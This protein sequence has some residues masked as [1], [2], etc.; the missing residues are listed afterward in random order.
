MTDDS[1]A[2]SY[3]FAALRDLGFAQQQLGRAVVAY[4]AL[5]QDDNDYAERERYQTKLR[6]T[7]VETQKHI[8][9]ALDNLDK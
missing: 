6:E 4:W 5:Q 8:D 1:Q 9:D 2:Q 3:R 7:L